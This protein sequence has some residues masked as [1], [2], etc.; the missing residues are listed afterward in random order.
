M[1]H[2][3]QQKPK[4]SSQPSHWLPLGMCIGLSLG[5]S[6]GS[7]MG[8]ISIGM[9]I[10]MSLGVAVGSLLDHAQKSKS[11]SD[12]DSI[13]QTGEPADDQFPPSDAS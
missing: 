13:R 10:G 12:T 5:M 9:C 3:H 8:N 11:E 2:S 6:I 4:P 1:N 7:F